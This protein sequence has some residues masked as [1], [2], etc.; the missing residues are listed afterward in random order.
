MIPEAALP[1]DTMRRRFGIPLT[2]AL[3]LL[4]AMVRPNWPLDSVQPYY[5][6]AGLSTIWAVIDSIRLQVSK[7]GSSQLLS[8]VA[9]A[10]W[11]LIAWPLAFP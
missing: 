9:L 10:A 5:I 11:M 6:L 1:G 8:P 3:L 4:T 7:H 2:A